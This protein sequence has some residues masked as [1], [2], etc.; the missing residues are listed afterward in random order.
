MPATWDRNSPLVR[1]AFFLAMLLT[2]VFSSV[3]AV[4]CSVVLLR[5]P[6]LHDGWLVLA[7]GAGLLATIAVT[8]AVAL[9]FVPRLQAR[10]AGDAATL[11]PARVLGDARLEED[12]AV[13]RVCNAL[14]HGFAQPL[15]GV[16]AYSEMLTNTQH[17]NDDGTRQELEGLREGTLQLQQLLQGVR[18]ALSEAPGERGYTSLVEQVETVAIRPLPRV[19]VRLGNYHEAPTGMVRGPGALE[20]LE[21]RELAARHRDRTSTS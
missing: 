9:C 16:V 14:L 20:T 21:R 2:A 10:A 7:L 5:N 15:T 17:A 12:A 8:S 11:A 4:A 19:P 13:E 3:Q 1:A 18:E 6:T